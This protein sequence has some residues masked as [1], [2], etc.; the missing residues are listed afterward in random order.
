MTIDRGLIDTSL[1]GAYDSFLITGWVNNPTSYLN[2]F[3][4]ATL[5]SRW[6]G[7]GLALVEYMYGSVPLVSTKVDAIPYV[8]DDGV[9]GLLVEPNSPEEAAKAVIRIHN[10]PTLAT[11]L[12]TNGLTVAKDKYDVRRVVKQTQKLYQDILSH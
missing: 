6:E 7:F 2:C 3:D 5:L 9:D 11:K 4:V 10:D 8:V 12:V 1:L